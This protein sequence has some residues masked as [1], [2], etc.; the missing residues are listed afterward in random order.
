M[1]SGA[2]S[3]CHDL[4]LTKNFIGQARGAMVVIVRGK[5]VWDFAD[6]L[7]SAEDLLTF[8]CLCWFRDA[9]QRKQ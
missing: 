7:E 4:H 9:N 1:T 8:P 5:L 3:F 2:V 6:L